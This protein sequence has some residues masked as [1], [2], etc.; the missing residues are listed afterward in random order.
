MKRH[1]PAVAVFCLGAVLL[2]LGIVRGEAQTVLQKAV[3][4]CM[5]CIGIG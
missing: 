2:T 4:I 3:I 5:E 1:L